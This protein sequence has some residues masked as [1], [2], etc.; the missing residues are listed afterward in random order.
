MTLGEFFNKYAVF[1]S[2][3]NG[4][5]TRRHIREVSKVKVNIGE[6]WEYVFSTKTELVLEGSEYKLDDHTVTFNIKSTEFTTE[7]LYQAEI[8]GGLIA[9]N[10]LN[11]RNLT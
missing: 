11:D 7:S 5:K 4:K 6:G 10:V 9:V 3:I 2:S 1:I 8:S